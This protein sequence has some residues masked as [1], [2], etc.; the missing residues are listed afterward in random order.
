LIAAIFAEEGLLVFN[1]RDAR[2]AQ[3]ASPLYRICLDD[4]EVIERLLQDR[5]GALV[6]AGFKEQVAVRERGALIFFHR[7]SA[8]GPRFRLLRKEGSSGEAAWVLAGGS[9]AVS[10]VEVSRHLVTEPLRFSTSALFRPVLQDS[11]LPTVANVAGPGEINY[12]AQMEPLYAHFGLVPPLLVPRAR[13]RCVDARARRWLAQ[14][15]LGAAD[16]DLPRDALRAR[17]PTPVPEG[18]RSPADLRALV[19]SQIAPALDSIAASVAAAGDHLGRPIQRT[20]DSVA[21]ALIRLIERYERT[22]IERD[23]TGLRRIQRLERALYPDGVPQERYYGWPSLAGRVGVK[24]L[25][26][27]VLEKLQMND[28]FATGVWDLEP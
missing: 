17:L 3:L 25:K 11:L 14:A 8:T 1:P 9:Q 18:A 20:R 27:L 7:D 15:G 4:S 12:F 19:A 6:A 26:R 24:K 21:H 23:Q 2:V 10:H 5:R 16:L 22:L 28:A 13:F